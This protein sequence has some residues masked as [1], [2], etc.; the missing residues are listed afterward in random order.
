[1]AVIESGTIQIAIS[2]LTVIGVVGYIIHTFY[3][4]YQAFKKTMYERINT[5]QEE[6]QDVVQCNEYRRIEERHDNIE[7]SHEIERR[8]GGGA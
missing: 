3:T 7:R 1:M 8:R 6:K 2:G 5:I 4:G